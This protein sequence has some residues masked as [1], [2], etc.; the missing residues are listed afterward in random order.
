MTNKKVIV[1]AVIFLIAGLLVY[2]FAATPSNSLDDD[3]DFAEGDGKDDDTNKPNVGGNVN[4]GFVIEVPIDGDLTGE[5]DDLN[6]TDGDDNSDSTEG[7]GSTGSTGSS[8]SSSSTSGTKKPASS[9]S[10]ST[11]TSGSNKPSNSN[12]NSNTTS[13]SNKPSSSSSNSSTTGGNDNSG[14]TGGN[15]STGATGGDDNSGSTSGNGNT[16]TTGGNDNS[17]STSGNGS[18]GTTG[19]ND[20]SGS[21]SGN[22]STGTTG[23][24][25][26][27][28]STGE[29]GN[30][31]TTGGNDNSG[32]TTPNEEKIG[33]SEV[34]ASVGSTNPDDEISISSSQEGT[35]IFLRGS[36]ETTSSEYDGIY[37]IQIKIMAPKI[38]SEETLKKSRF[39][40]MSNIY[41][42]PTTEKMGYNYIN[43]INSISSE[44]AYITITISLRGYE[45]KD[46]NSPF[47]LAVDWGD[48]EYTT[49]SIYF[50]SITIQN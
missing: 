13:G 39:K 49:Y 43:N 28:G 30:A 17:G 48:G 18:T 9:S 34:S 14:S 10:S 27:S 5:G 46:N 38:L 42:I 15:G 20:N 31:G 35:D 26:N 8:S 29:N 33:T 44:K 6:S 25:D 21:T 16:G 24:N 45:L 37:K 2:S 3:Y 23:G 40:A 36:I 22:G 32:S 19:G 50:S 1:I 12:S 11:S 47:K 4:G 7:T 41:G